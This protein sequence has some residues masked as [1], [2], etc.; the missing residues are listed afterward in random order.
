MDSL[1]CV[2][3]NVK[4]INNRIKRKTNINSILKNAMFKSNDPGESL[5]RKRTFK[6]EKEMGGPSLQL[7]IQKWE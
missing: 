1:N 7:F 5:V 3:Y 2:S 6:S 4:G